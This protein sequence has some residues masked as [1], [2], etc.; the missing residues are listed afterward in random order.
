MLD[1]LKDL[2]EMA[3][4]TIFALSVVA[5]FLAILVGVPA[6]VIIGALKLIGIV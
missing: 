1:F 6:F 5:A 4:L 3:I 2:C